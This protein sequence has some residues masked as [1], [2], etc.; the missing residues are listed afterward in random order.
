MTAAPEYHHN[1]CPKE[2][3]K[4][5]CEVHI[6]GNLRTGSSLL[7]LLWHQQLYCFYGANGSRCRLGAPSVGRCQESVFLSSVIPENLLFEKK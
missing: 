5:I 1:S 2:T 3:W 7:R 4:E 6:V